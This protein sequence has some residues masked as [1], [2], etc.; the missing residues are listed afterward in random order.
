[1]AFRTEVFFAG[2]LDPATMSEIA[3][4][5][6]GWSNN[7]P[8][9]VGVRLG[10]YLYVAGQNAITEAVTIAK[11]DLSNMN[12]VASCDS[13]AMY[14]PKSIITDGTYLYV[15]TGN[16]MIGETAKV[17]KVDPTTMTEIGLWD[18]GSEIFAGGLAWDGT[19][20]Y[21]AIADAAGDLAKLV[22]LDPATMTEVDRWTTSD[23]YGPGPLGYDGTYIYVGNFNGIVQ[24]DPATMSDLVGWDSGFYE[25]VGRTIVFDG[26]HIYCV[27]WKN[28]DSD[29]AVVQLDP[30][31]MTEVDRWSATPSRTPP[32]SDTFGLGWD[33]TYLYVAFMQNPSEVVQIDPATM[34]AVSTYTGSTNDDEYEY[35][36]FDVCGDA[37]SASVFFVGAFGVPDSGNY[38][39]FIKVDP[40]SL[41]ELGRFDDIINDYSVW[42]EADEDFVYFLVTSSAF[43][44]QYRLS[45]FDPVTMTEL[46]H[47]DFAAQVTGFCGDGTY[48]YVTCRDPLVPN[49]GAL[50][51]VRIADMVIVDSHTFSEEALGVTS[52]GTTYLYVFTRQS[53]TGSVYKMASATLAIVDQYDYAFPLFPNG[54][55]YHS[56]YI[57][58]RTNNSNIQ[59]DKID[60]G[61]M[62][63]AGQYNGGAA[64][65]NVPGGASVKVCGDGTYIY[66][67]RISGGIPSVIEKINAATM[68]YVS[69]YTDSA[70]EMH[71]L[72]LGDNI[73]VGTATLQRIDPSTMLPTGNMT[74]PA[75]MYDLS[76]DGTYLYIAGTYFAPQPPPSGGGGSMWAKL[77]AAGL[78]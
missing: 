31:T 14:E 62:A 77:V 28:D 65:V 38:P 34:D 71:A 1:M 41:S 17:V 39:S 36:F 35:Q 19:H 12:Q 33:G 27:V 52:D 3:Q 24:I 16:S 26:S 58:V 72:V 7:H 32:F 60:A 63:L 21:V 66:A 6:S 43:L 49:A 9:T 4:F 74:P 73:Y 10:G 44:N 53:G 46:G 23:W 45:K 30:A 64:Q 40:V 67:I 37:A 76:W 15:S 18:A 78:F 11:I 61:T 59:I 13:S 57:Y 25:C 51:K 68:N 5:H 70:D 54:I 22:Q 48:L 47:V 29:A 20:V 42:T 69:D 56:G 50:Y 8:W 2:Q 55:G 75:S